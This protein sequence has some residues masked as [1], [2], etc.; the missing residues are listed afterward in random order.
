MTK[1]SIGLVI[2]AILLVAVVSFIA[3][4]GERGGPAQ[5][6][7]TS[8]AG[9]VPIAWHADKPPRFWLCTLVGD[10]L[11]IGPKV[12]IARLNDGVDLR[13]RLVGVGEPPVGGFPVTA[14]PA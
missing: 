9:D 6:T 8:T 1:R 7:T 2:A 10:G 11:G 12:D 14:T 5:A 4:A 13:Q 3:L